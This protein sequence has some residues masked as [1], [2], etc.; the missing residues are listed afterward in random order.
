MLSNCT[1][2][3]HLDTA[4]CNMHT[5]CKCFCLPVCASGCREWRICEATVIIFSLHLARVVNKQMFLLRTYTHTHTGM[6]T[7]THRCTQRAVKRQVKLLRM[8]EMLADCKKGGQSASAPASTQPS[9]SLEF[10]LE[11][12]FPSPRGTH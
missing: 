3:S 4:Q 1:W 8:L 9:A 11:V 7:L 5:T 6:P 10:P 2:K 12:T